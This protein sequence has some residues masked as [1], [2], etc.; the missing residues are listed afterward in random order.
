MTEGNNQILAEPSV[1]YTMGSCPGEELEQ[2]LEILEKVKSPKYNKQIKEA[3]RLIA[4]A[5]SWY[6]STILREVM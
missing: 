6:D 5:K 2:A 3:V 4:S 1:E